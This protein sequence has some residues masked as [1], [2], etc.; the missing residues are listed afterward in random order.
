MYRTR[1]GSSVV[2]NAP[3]LGPGDR[4]FESSLPDHHVLVAQRIERRPS[5]PGGEG[6]N[7]SGRVLGMVSVA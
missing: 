6:S 7:P 2:A 4:R 5:K 3:G 1:A